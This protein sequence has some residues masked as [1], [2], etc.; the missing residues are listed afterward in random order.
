MDKILKEADEIS[1]ILAASVIKLKQT[2]KE[3]K[4][5]NTAKTKSH[6]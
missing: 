6:L 5:V 1:K 3:N 4:E 2:N